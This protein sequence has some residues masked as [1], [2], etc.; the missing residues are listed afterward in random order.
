MERVIE[1][2]EMTGRQSA[3]ETLSVDIQRLPTASLSDCTGTQ[4]Y[5]LNGSY[6]DCSYI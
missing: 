2:K 4:C 6:D 5:A 1:E 3:I